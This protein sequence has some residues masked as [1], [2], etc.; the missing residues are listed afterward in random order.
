MNQE[1]D[2]ESETEMSTSTFIV[3]CVCVLFI[4]CSLLYL[5]WVQRTSRPATVLYQKWQQPLVKR[6]FAPGVQWTPLSANFR[7]KT[8]SIVVILENTAN[9]SPDSASGAVHCIVYDLPPDSWHFDATSRLPEPAQYGMNS[10]GVAG[11]TPVNSSE[12]GL[13]RWSIYALNDTLGPKLIHAS[14][15]AKNAAGIRK[16]MSGNIVTE[17]TQLVKQ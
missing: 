9:S 5:L 17:I 15:T 13:Y 4:A 7:S 10:F 6:R 16:L 3:I 2:L 12:N 1:D 11:Y 14:T 8:K